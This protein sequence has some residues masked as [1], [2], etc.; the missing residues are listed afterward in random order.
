VLFLFGTASLSIDDTAGQAINAREPFIAAFETSMRKASL[1]GTVPFGNVSV[2]SSN[3]TR[4]RDLMPIASIVA[5]SANQNATLT[6][7]LSVNEPATN[8]TVVDQPQNSKDGSANA[9]RH[10]TDAE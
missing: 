10:A 5:H 6:Y 3:I 8:G 7:L 2:T 1:T 9:R 4:H